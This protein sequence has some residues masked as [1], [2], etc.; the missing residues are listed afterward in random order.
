MG[1]PRR[2]MVS[3]RWMTKMRRLLRCSSMRWMSRIRA[4]SSIFCRSQ[5]CNSASITK[6][7]KISPIVPL[8]M[9]APANHCPLPRMV[10][11]AGDWPILVG[12]GTLAR[13]R[14]EKD[15]PQEDAR[16]KTADMC[17]PC[18]SFIRDLVTRRQHSA[19]QLHHEPNPEKHHCRNLDDGHKDNDW[20]QG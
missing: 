6:I 12:D 18:D 4:V 3:S 7:Q 13:T 19:E 11:F 20:H 10:G 1:N 9:W 17:P 16:C 14:W 2:L 5:G 15:R 8:M